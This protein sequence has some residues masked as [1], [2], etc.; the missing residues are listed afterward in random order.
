MAENSALITMQR[1][2]HIFNIALVFLQL[3]SVCC[4]TAKVK[5]A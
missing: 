3:V 2:N 4:D 5:V 1:I